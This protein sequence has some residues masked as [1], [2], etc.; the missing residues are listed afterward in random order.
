[1]TVALCCVA[2]RPGVLGPTVADQHRG[3]AAE[4]LP[5]RKRLAD[6]AAGG[7]N[8]VLADLDPHL[9]D[10]ARSDPGPVA[11][12]NGLGD[13]IHRLEHV[14]RAGGDERLLRDDRVA[15]DRQHVLIMNPDPFAEPGAVA[16][17]EI[18]R[19]L[20]VNVADDDPLPDLRAEKPQYRDANSRRNLQRVS[21]EDR[22]GDHP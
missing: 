6:D 10:A 19:K 2:S 20:H 7:H 16:D 12:P 5:W 8:G 9:H 1:M 14:V 13:E 11:D 15:S 4:D 17:F 3:I 21:D 18:P 22:L